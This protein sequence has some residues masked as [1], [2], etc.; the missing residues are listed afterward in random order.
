[1]EGNWF[2]IHVEE[3]DGIGNNEKRRIKVTNPTLKFEEI[4]S[5]TFVRRFKG[6]GVDVH[7]ATKAE[8][9]ESGAIC[10][11]C[12]A[13]KIALMTSM[14]G[15]AEMDSEPYE[16]GVKFGDNESIQLQDYITLSIH[17]CDS[18]GYVHS[19]NIE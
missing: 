8:I 13:G 5:V 1:M 18:C 15:D 9:I 11:K 16:E 2:L 12:N 14:V 19:V 17:A 4:E 7:P 6:S 10:E 3:Q